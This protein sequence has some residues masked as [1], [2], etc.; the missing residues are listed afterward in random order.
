M[1]VATATA[2]R[3]DALATAALVMGREGLAWLEGEPDV[4]AVMVTRSSCRPDRLLVRA[5]RGLRDRLTLF[6]RTAIDESGS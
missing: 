5:S 1:T 4:E 6:D 3:A 2:M